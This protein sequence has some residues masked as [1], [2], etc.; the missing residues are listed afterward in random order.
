MPSERAGTKLSNEQPKTW[1]RGSGGP[2]T[3]PLLKQTGGLS[4]LSSS[5]ETWE[6]ETRFF[7]TNCLVQPRRSALKCFRSLKGSVCSQTHD[8]RVSCA[9]RELQPRVRAWMIQQLERA[10][11]Q[12]SLRAARE[13]HEDGSFLT[14]P[15]IWA[16]RARSR[17]EPL[18]VRIVAGKPRADRW[19]PGVAGRS[20]VLLPG[21]PGGFY[22]WVPG[23]FRPFVRIR[24][25][26][27]RL[28]VTSPS[29]R[30]LVFRV[31]TRH[32]PSQRQVSVQE[33]DQ[34]YGPTKTEQNL[35]KRAQRF[36]TYE[37]RIFIKL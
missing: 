15:L 34:N 13:D 30:L 36:W 24:L 7:R 33:T 1:H 18:Q 28:D 21:S 3:G 23:R 20:L 25:G 37:E 4:C 10:A 5:P 27:V 19:S 31:W 29:D 2:G 14:C 26:S 11:P 17:G 35:N 16:S 9:P 22:G 12:S 8:V 32:A 6:T